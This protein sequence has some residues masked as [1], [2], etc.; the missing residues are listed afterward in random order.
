MLIL[1]DDLDHAFATVVEQDEVFEKVDEIRLR[2]DALQKRLHVDDT[3]LGLVKP[4]PL[5][6]EFIRSRVAAYASIDAV[7]KDDE[8]VVMEDVGNGVLVVGQVLVVGSAGVAM[9]VLEFH[10][11]E[12]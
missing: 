5:T 7:A 6:E 3:W 1:S 12:R 11:Q 4:L 9:D 10:E 2:A 8:G